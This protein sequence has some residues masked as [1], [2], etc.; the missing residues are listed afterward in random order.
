[1]IVTST[2]I[3]DVKIL[4]PKIFT[5]ERG[6][7]FES[8]HRTQ[9]LAVGMP[10]EFVQDNHSG[11]GRHVLRGLHYQL[12]RPQGKLVRVLTGEVLDVAVDIRPGSKTFGHH[13][14]ASL[15]ARNRHM[16]WI[17]P[18]FAHG[19]LVRSRFAEVLYKVTTHYA[20][21][22][23]RSIIWN[24]P[25]LAIDWGIMSAPIVSRKDS[26]AP[27]LRDADLYGRAEVKE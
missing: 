18:G 11:S 8:F 2:P 26:E 19:F 23:E 6:F 25:D 15:S 17:P 13:V 5:D 20:P 16:M 9:F 3:H 10:G 24:D 7:F 1:V 22:E 27:R 4:Q 12:R 14:A 21:E